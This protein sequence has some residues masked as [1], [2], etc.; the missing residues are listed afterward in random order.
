M[1][2][3][4]DTMAWCLRYEVSGRFCIKGMLREWSMTRNSICKGEV[5][6]R[7]SADLLFSSAFLGTAEDLGRW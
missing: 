2:T 5:G 1:R 4:M 3:C 7:Y 6:V